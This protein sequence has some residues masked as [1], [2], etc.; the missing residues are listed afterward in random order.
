MRLVLLVL[1]VEEGWI[2]VLLHE[3][4]WRLVN[5]H[6][7]HLFLCLAGL[8]LS[9]RFL[10]LF[11]LALLLNALKLIEDV[12]IVE[13][14]VR[15]F[16]P[17]DISLDKPFNSSLNHRHFEQLVN[18]GPLGRVPFQHHGEDVGDGGREMRWQRC[19]V[20]LNNLLGELVQRAC[21][22]GWRQSG[23]LV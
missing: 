12:L 3:W 19:V 22:E 11:R 15:E 20:A 18:G 7:G 17:E 2:V 10:F 1:V 6:V 9:S 4:S 14:R 23:H 16:L 8:L 5:L 21:V 13:E